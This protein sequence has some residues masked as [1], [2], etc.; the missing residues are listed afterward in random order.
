[1]D[2]FDNS[3]SFAS[4]DITVVCCLLDNTPKTVTCGKGLSCAGKCS[5]LGASLCPSGRCTDDQ[6]T[7]Q[8]DF[9]GE[10]TGTSIA[11]LASSDLKYCTNSEYNCIVRKHSACCYNRNCLK[12][13]GR[14]EACK[15]LDYLTGGDQ[16][17]NFLFEDKLPHF[18]PHLS[19][20][21]TTGPRHMEVPANGG[22]YTRSHF[23]GRRCTILPR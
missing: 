5:A 17:F 14:K 11:T 4:N 3:F 12:R 18:R 1:M 20:S 22:A 10:D 23:F 21:S 15:D 2:F 13:P 9:D 6:K 19:H 8:L 16:I 7:C